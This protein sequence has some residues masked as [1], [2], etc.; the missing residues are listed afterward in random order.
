MPE[1]LG[2]LIKK[3]GGTVRL[4]HI[5]HFTQVAFELEWC[6]RG[7]GIIVLFPNPAFYFRIHVR[8]RK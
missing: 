4:S 5:G 1:I 3:G 7:K 2:L 8:V 6:E